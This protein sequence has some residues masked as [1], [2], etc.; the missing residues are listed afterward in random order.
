MIFKRH[1]GNA[2]SSGALRFLDNYHVVNVYSFH[3][4]QALKYIL[5]LV[6]RGIII[7]KNIVFSSLRMW[8]ISLYHTLGNL[9]VQRDTKP[10]H[11]DPRDRRRGRGDGALYPKGKLGKKRIESVN[12]RNRHYLLK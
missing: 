10:L 9:R 3:S 5:C 1:V 8:T 12:V 11:G 6:L 4:S 2:A 7:K